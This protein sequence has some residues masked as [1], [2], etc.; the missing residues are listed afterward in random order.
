M[1]ADTKQNIVFINQ[2]SGYL[3]IDI[4]NAFKQYECR[5]IIT[6]K[7]I[8]RNIPLDSSIKVEKIISYNRSSAFKRIFT[9]CFGFAQILWVIK[10]KYQ[11]S[12]LFIVTNPPFTS[13]I[14]L[15]CKN[16]FSILIYDIY[17]DALIAYKYIDDK[18]VIAKI[19]KRSNRKVFSKAENVFT[20]GVEMK[21]V[22]GQ[23]VDDKK[24]K[25]VTNWTD[26]TSLKP[27]P[28]GENI[29]IKDHKLEDKF[30]VMYSGNLGHS[31]SIEVLIEIASAMENDN[32]YFIIIGEGDK[33]VMIDKMMKQKQLDNCILLPW[34]DVA[35]LPFSLS[36]ADIAVVTLGE[37]AS[38]LSVPSKTFNLMSVG[39]PLLCIAD[40][41]SE[42]ASLVN[43]FEIGECFYP[44][45]IEK[46]IEFIS[47]IKV[48]LT[49]R[50]KLKQNA[51]K[52]SKQFGSE[53]VSKFITS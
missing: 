37:E 32:V 9:W 6:G 10:T 12:D 41:K 26:N 28:K 23:Y 24:I 33:K 14:P 34:Q 3:M 31:H 44:S 39:V 17:P 8:E 35:M 47:E 27:I 52:A 40:K 36:A 53:N 19:W 46:M 7:L 4:V 1:K 42:L 48:N 21:K 29:F 2:N 16:K 38:N 45:E 43:R 51:V 5:T 18:S 13:F 11:K 30:V 50:N 25:I 15:F 49:Y 22:I 20:V